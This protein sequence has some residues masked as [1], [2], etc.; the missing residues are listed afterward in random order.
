MTPK[1]IYCSRC[2]GYT[3]KERM[4]D[5]ESLLG[6]HE[7]LEDCVERLREMIEDLRRELLP[8]S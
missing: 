1:P 2:G 5:G 4:T 3:G 7:H 6:Y 8:L